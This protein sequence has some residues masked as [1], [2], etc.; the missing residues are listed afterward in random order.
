MFLRFHHDLAKDEIVEKILE[1]KLI[2]IAQDTYFIMT[3]SIDKIDK[4][5]GEFLFQKGVEG[6]IN[7]GGN[8]RSVV[9]K[10]KFLTM[11]E[12]LEYLKA[13]TEIALTREDLR[14]EYIKYLKKRVNELNGI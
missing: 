7:E 10:G 5:S 1:K 11:G 6:V 4:K 8:V 13:T 3:V 14:D 12:P 2:G 9:T